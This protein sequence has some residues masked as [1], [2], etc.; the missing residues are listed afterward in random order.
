MSEQ[1]EHAATFHFH[2]ALNDFLHKRRRGQPIHY[3]FRGTPA[4]KDSIE[5]LGVP[6]PEVDVVLVNEKPTPFSC[7]LQSGDVVEAYPVEEGRTWPAG[8]TFEEQNPPP[9]RFVLDVHLGT[10]AKSMRILGLDTYYETDLSDSAIAGIAA[11]QQRVVLTRD[12]GLLKQKSI[13]WG[14]WLRSQQTEEQLEE[15]IRRYHLYKSFRP[16]ERCLACNVPVQEVSKQEVL[17]HLPPKTQRYF[18][19]FYRCPSCQRIYW[20]GS[21]YERMQQYIA[22]IRGN[23]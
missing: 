9:T 22:R 5:A 19:E 8:Y 16:F 7:Q 10:L 4:V 13:T 21:H 1:P 20:K 3:T 23:R 18:H 11:S 2:G 14:Y 15:V 17:E 6:H 12:I